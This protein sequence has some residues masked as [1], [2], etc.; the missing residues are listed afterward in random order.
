MSS[1]LP[2]DHAHA[3]CPGFSIQFAIMTRLV[4]LIFSGF[5]IAISLLLS[6]SRP[7]SGAGYGIYTPNDFPFFNGL[8]FQYAG[9][10]TAHPVRHFP[11]KGVVIPSLTNEDWLYY[12]LDDFNAGPQDSYVT[13]YRMRA[14]GSDRQQ[15]GRFVNNNEGW[16]GGDYTFSP[17]QQWMAYTSPAFEPPTILF[18]CQRGQA[19]S[20]RKLISVEFT[21][22]GSSSLFVESKDG[23]IASFLAFKTDAQ[24]VWHSPFSQELGLPGKLV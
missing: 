1:R 19:Q 11:A 23:I 22:K 20:L 7:T 9:S 10:L 14:D 18:V 8:H 6:A 3:H 12:V 2:E 15:L 16:S 24:Q 13:L 5:I 21:V 17:D 4:V